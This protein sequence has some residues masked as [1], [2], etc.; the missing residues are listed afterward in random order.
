MCS[1]DFLH[2]NLPWG[3]QML[4]FFT[5]RISAVG[6][7][8]DSEQIPERLLGTLEEMLVET[9]LPLPQSQCQGPCGEV[10]RWS[11]GYTG[12]SRPGLGVEGNIITES[13][14]AKHVRSE[15]LPSPEGHVCAQLQHLPGSCQS[16]VIKAW[17]RER[18]LASTHTPAATFPTWGSP[19]MFSLFIWIL[20]SHGHTG[21]PPARM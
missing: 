21:L 17:T 6:L 5:C 4:I 20:H 15:T 1:I 19:I 14:W 9:S 16:S 12:L 11:G 10:R 2:H 3:C 8:L 13:L 7:E 18:E